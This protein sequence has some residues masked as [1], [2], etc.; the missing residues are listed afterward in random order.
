MQNE[1]TMFTVFKNKYD[2]E[3]VSTESVG[4]ASWGMQRA[5]KTNLLSGPLE[6]FPLLLVPQSVPPRTVMSF[7]SLCWGF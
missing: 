7:I 2:E 4:N 5:E 6:M 3:I 1:N